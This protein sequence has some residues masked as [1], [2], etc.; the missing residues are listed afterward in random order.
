MTDTHTPEPE[1]TETEMSEQKAVRLA[2]RDRLLEVVGD[3]YPVGIRE[4][5]RRLA[6]ETEG[7]GQAIEAILA[8]SPLTRA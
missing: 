6:E 5:S 2:K 3:A 8:R 4:M 7:R 1:L